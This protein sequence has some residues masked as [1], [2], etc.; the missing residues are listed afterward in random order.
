MLR[1]LLIACAL[2]TFGCAAS[3]K[4]PSHTPNDVAMQE[5]DLDALDREIQVRQKVE[6]L[7]EGDSCSEERIEEVLR[8]CTEADAECDEQALLQR[9]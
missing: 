9:S 3:P 2:F 1:N 4:A 5:R 6:V 8:I 7:C